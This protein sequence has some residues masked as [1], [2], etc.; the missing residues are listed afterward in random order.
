GR[1]EQVA[2][3]I[4]GIGFKRAVLVGELGHAA[5][6]V[7][8]I[9]DAV[10]VAAFLNQ[11]VG[12]LGV[13][14]IGVVF[15]GADAAQGILHRNDLANVVVDV[16][17]GAAQ[18]IGHFGQPVIRIILVGGGI[19]AAVSDGGQVPVGIVGALLGEAEG[20]GVGRCLVRLVIG[21]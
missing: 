15:A 9:A 8:F 13:A 12:V 10:G 5:H 2:V 6:R 18:S 11:L 19:A 4:V 16:G 20:V 3:F 7:V 21:R 14:V 17:S 1:G